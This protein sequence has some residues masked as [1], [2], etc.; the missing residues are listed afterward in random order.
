MIPRII[1]VGVVVLLLIPTF[2]RIRKQLKEEQN[3]D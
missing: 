1:L 3:E 2:V